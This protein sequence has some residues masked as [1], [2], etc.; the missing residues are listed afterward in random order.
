MKK[1]KS[2][3]NLLKIEKDKNLIELGK[4]L[5]NNNIVELKNLNHYPNLKLVEK[6]LYQMKSNLSKSEENENILK[7]LNKKFIFLKKNIN[8]LVNHIK[9]TLKKLL[10]Q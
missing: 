2:E 3:I 9:K 5:K 10:K 8:L 7:N 1:I 4:I 6:E